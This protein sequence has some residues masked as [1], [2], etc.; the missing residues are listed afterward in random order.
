MP[1]HNKKE[2]KARR[3]QLRKDATPQEIKLWARLRKN[4]LGFKFRRQESIGWYIVD[5]YCFAK[6]LA[7]EID[8]SHHSRQR[9]YDKVRTDYLGERGVTVLRFWD[10]EIEKHLEEVLAVIM[11][12]L[13]RQVPFAPL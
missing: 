5:F 12:T 8:G 10:N 1:T 4:Q 13:Q 2:L 3:Q 7:I 11:Q 9:E 6:K